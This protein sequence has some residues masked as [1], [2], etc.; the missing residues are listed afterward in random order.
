MKNAEIVKAY[1]DR[2]ALRADH[3]A[4]K[5]QIAN[6]MKQEQRLQRELTLLDSVTEI[7]EGV[8]LA[9]NAKNYDNGPAL[10]VHAVDFSIARWA[11]VYPNAHNGGKDWGLKMRDTGSPTGLSGEKWGGTGWPFAE[12]C[13]AARAYVA[14]GTEPDE[15]WVEMIKMRHM[16]DPEGKATKRRRDAFEAAFTAGHTALAGELLLGAKKLDVRMRVLEAERDAKKAKEA[17]P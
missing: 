12:A 14:H 1:P 11:D 15:K 6:L 7:F 8:A 9:V 13:A 2:K 16:L 17:R 3:E 5:R 10:D 4:L